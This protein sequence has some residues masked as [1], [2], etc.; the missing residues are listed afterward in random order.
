M[1]NGGGKTFIYLFENE[2]RGRKH[3]EKVLFSFFF[4]SNLFGAFDVPPFSFLVSFLFSIWNPERKRRMNNKFID[5]W[6][7][8]SRELVSTNQQA[9]PS[10]TTVLTKHP[11]VMTG[12]PRWILVIKRSRC[13]VPR[14][15]P[16]MDPF[17]DGSY[18]SHGWCF[19][20]ASGCQLMRRRME[21]F[22]P[23]EM[24]A[25]APGRSHPSR[26]HFLYFFR[27]FQFRFHF[28]YFDR[29]LKPNFK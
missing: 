13:N 9:A 16:W 2:R 17:I 10:E 23:R 6:T 18:R 1:Q 21:A 5:Q 8:A 28:C 29:T 22:H 25:T 11:P 14:K 24:R 26:W 12:I 15:G 27:F 20:A 4:W 19:M 3:I 7:V